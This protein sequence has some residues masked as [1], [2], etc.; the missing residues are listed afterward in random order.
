M[1]LAPTVL[2]IADRAGPEVAHLDALGIRSWI[3]ADS[4]EALGY[5]SRTRPPLIFIDMDLPGC[6]A[7]RTA[8]I[9]ASLHSSA[10]IILTTNDHDSVQQARQTPPEGV[11]AVVGKPLSPALV[12]VLAEMAFGRVCRAPRHQNIPSKMKEAS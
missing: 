6:S 11:L 9:A 10:A 4:A 3:S 7:A 2:I 12:R 5:L 1:T 8:A